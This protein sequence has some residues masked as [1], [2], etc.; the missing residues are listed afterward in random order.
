MQDL[1]D[2]IV[3]RIPPGDHDEVVDNDR[4]QEFLPV[5]G[6]D[7]GNIGVRIPHGPLDQDP[8]GFE[9]PDELGY[10]DVIRVSRVRVFCFVKTH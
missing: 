7:P 9:L 3:C 2:L 4:G 5:F 1:F 10:P 8:F 6:D